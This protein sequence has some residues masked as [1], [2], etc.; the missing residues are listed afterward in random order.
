M[1]RYAITDPKYYGSDPLFFSRF[2]KRILLF[3]T[4][5]MVVLRDKQIS[6]YETLAKSFLSLKPYFPET[7]FL[8]HSD[9]LLAASLGADGIHLPSAAFD[10]ISRAKSLGLWT[11]VST[12]TLDEAV[13]AEKEGADAVT[14]SPIFP[15]PGK[16]EPKG[17]EK[18]KE[19]KD[20]ISIK[21]FALGGIVTDDQIKAVESAGVDGFASIRYFVK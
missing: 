10:R 9:E 17:L 12:H 1:L 7:K 18:L 14:F 21:L 6:G 5:D 4:V 15:T 8:L 3:Q 16:G 13:E 11:I 19:I 2:L 20:R